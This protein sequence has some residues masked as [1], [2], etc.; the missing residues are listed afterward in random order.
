MVLTRR[1]FGKVAV[2]SL[3]AAA[4]ALK[5]A[6]LSAEGLATKP[7]SR[8]GGVQVGINTPLSLSMSNY[9]PADQLLATLTELNLSGVELRAQ[10]VE[11]FLGSPVALAEAAAQAAGGRRGGRGRA[12]AG[13]PPAAGT[14]AAEP[15]APS[16]RGGPRAAATPEQLAAQNAAA[17]ET[18]KWRMGVS[19]DRVKAYRKIF[20]DAGVLIQV[21]KWDGIFDFSDDELD[22]AFQVSRALGASALS[23]EITVGK[24]KRV[25]AFADKHKMLIGYHNHAGMKPEAWEAAFAEAR[26]NGANVDIGH[27]VAGNNASPVSFMKKYSDRISHIHV[28]DRKMNEGAT[29]PLGQGDTPVREILQLMRTNKWTYQA[30]LEPAYA[31]PEGSTL[32]AELAKCVQYCKECLLG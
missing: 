24:T 17:E 14:S 21:V 9:T 2:A 12:G 31:V 7:N 1:E 26:Y 32:T 6:G 8:W 22:Y 20:E 5:Q 27:F 23:T 15:A 18:R 19:M 13:V 29:V 11:F 28:K 16:G 30:T 10:P 4:L 25:G 3:P